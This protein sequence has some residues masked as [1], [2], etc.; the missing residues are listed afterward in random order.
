MT[1]QK[2]PPGTSSVF[3]N[4]LASTPK[5]NQGPQGPGMANTL[6]CP[7]C[8]AVRERSQMQPNEPLVCRYCG[9][10]LVQK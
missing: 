3:A 9:T 10:G 5:Y 8:G 2:K 7:N 4:A 6:L 1:E